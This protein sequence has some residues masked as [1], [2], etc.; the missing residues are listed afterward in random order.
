M[1]QEIRVILKVT[2]EVE[3][4]L[5]SAS[6]PKPDYCSNTIAIKILSQ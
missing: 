2:I 3:E 5:I 4:K 1:S 6:I